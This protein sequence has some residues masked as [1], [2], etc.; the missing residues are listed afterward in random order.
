MA[1]LF[2]FPIRASRKVAAPDD[3]ATIKPKLRTKESY[4]R[5]KNDPEI[6]TRCAAKPAPDLH[7]HLAHPRL[8]KH[9]PPP[10]YMGASTSPHT[11]DKGAVDLPI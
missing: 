10:F 6:K 9:P 3:D 2:V 8:P 5:C 1:V 4:A 11:P 7:R